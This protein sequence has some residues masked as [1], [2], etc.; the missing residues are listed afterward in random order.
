MGSATPDLAHLDGYQPD[1]LGLTPAPSAGGCGRC[2]A[3]LSR[4]PAH[5][6]PPGRAPASARPA[7]LRTIRQF[8][9]L[10]HLELRRTLAEQLADAAL[11]LEQLARVAAMLESI[12]V[13]GL[14]A[15]AGGPAVHPASSLALHGRRPAQAALTGS[16]S[17]AWA[18]VQGPGLPVHGL[19]P[20]FAAGPSPALGHGADDRLPAGLDRHVLDPDHLLAF[21]AVA[22]EGVGQRRERSAP[23]CR[24]SQLLQRPLITAAGTKPIEIAVCGFQCP[25]SPQRIRDRA[26]QRPVPS[27]A[28]PV[29]DPHPQSSVIDGNNKQH[30]GRQHHE[31]GV[32]SKTNAPGL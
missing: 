14:G 2:D 6:S 9:A 25:A 27:L 32:P 8:A 28:H 22:V 31:P 10:H 16:G 24:P 12:P 18:Q 26:T 19:D 13:T 17:A 11:E 23:A 7:R 21:A 15:T 30:C 4:G 20:H 1:T 29:T 5:R 3:V